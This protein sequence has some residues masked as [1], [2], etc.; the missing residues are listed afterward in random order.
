MN[1]LPNEHHPG[2]RCSCGDCLR[3]YPKM[4]IPKRYMPRVWIDPALQCEECSQLRVRIEALEAALVELVRLK[5]DKTVIMAAWPSSWEIAWA[6][7]S[8]LMEEK[9]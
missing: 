1:M 7:A 6:E 5:S 2:P 4:K 9:K 3:A 8:R